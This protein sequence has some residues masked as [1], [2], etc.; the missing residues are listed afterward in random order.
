MSKQRWFCEECGSKGEV[1][2][3]DNKGVWSVLQL[4][5]RQH[6]AHSPSCS[7]TVYG[8]RVVNESYVAPADE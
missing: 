8:L 1:I 6:R 5:D 4:I 7:V 3:D 2:Y